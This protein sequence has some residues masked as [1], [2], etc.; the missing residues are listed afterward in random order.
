MNNNV[1]DRKNPEKKN[2]N[3]KKFLIIYAVIACL[4]LYSFSIEP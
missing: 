2:N 3:N 4:F 1:N